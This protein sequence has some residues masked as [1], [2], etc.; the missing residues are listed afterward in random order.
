MGEYADMML[1]G[2]LCE[3]CGSFIDDDGAE[4]FPR[5]CSKQCARD[6]GADHAAPANPEPWLNPKKANCPHCNKRV[7]VVGL[8]DHIR[9]AHKAFSAENL[10]TE[11]EKIAGEWYGEVGQHIDPLIH[12]LRRGIELGTEK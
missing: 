5:Y 9:D 7:K 4:G 2:T 10:K 6:R 12:A 8:A 11:A 1:D 3:C